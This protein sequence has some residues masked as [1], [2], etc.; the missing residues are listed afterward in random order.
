MLQHTVHHCDESTILEIV[1]Q[2]FALSS[3]TLL[4]LQLQQPFHARTDVGCHRNLAVLCVYDRIW[5]FVCR[6]LGIFNFRH[7]ELVPIGHQIAKK[8]QLLLNVPCP[9]VALQHQFHLLVLE[10]FDLFKFFVEQRT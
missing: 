9:T 1:L 4:P 6:I 2:E 3:L 10:C 7:L 8:D 5:S